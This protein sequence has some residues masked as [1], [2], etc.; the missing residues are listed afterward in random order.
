MGK[1][2]GGSGKD[3]GGAARRAGLAMGAIVLGATAVGATGLGVG[4]VGTLTDFGATYAVAREVRKEVVVGATE[5]EFPIWR[6]S[7]W[8][9]LLFSPDTNGT[10]RRKTHSKMDASRESRSQFHGRNIYEVFGVSGDAPISEIKKWYRRMALIHHPDR[11]SEGKDVHQASLDFQELTRMIQFISDPIRRSYY[12]QTGQMEETGSADSS[13]RGKVSVEDIDVFE[14]SYVGSAEEAKDILEA[15]RKCRGDLPQ[16]LECILLSKSSSISRYRTIVERAIAKG[17]LKKCKRWAETSESSQTYL[18]Q[19]DVKSIPLGANDPIR[20]RSTV[21][22]VYV[23]CKSL[24]EVQ[25]EGLVLT[26][27]QRAKKRFLDQ[28]SDLE[29]RFSKRKRSNHDDSLPSEEEF[30]RIQNRLLKK[31]RKPN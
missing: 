15:Y 14:A 26:M 30:K 13:S 5:V 6:Y 17:C 21:Q 19:V 3:G 8:N 28:V 7:R 4:E 27:R 16:M 31:K 22:S 10:T 24:T 12:D 11:Q 23:D 29:K 9:Q 18:E 20:E 1:D 25:S 2:F